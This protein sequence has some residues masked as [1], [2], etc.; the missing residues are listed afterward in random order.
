MVQLVD[1]ILKFFTDLSE[2]LGFEMIIPAN[3]PYVTD[4]ITPLHDTYKN[5]I[6]CRIVSGDHY[7]S[8]YTVIRSVMCE[9][10]CIDIAPF[11]LSN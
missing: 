8:L 5:G 7:K 6:G 2:L 10:L 4:L 9:K 3:S 11:T 1:D